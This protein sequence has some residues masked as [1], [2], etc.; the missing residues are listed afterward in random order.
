LARKFWKT[1]NQQRKLKQKTEK[2]IR[3]KNKKSQSAK[4]KS[5]KNKPKNKEILIKTS[6]KTSNPQ[7]FKKTRKF[8]KTQARIRGV[9][10]N[11]CLLRNF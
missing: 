6:P 10:R 3:K 11:F 8:K 4:Q 1:K 5:A 9:K 2:Q 7:V